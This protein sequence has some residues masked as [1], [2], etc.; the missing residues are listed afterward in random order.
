MGYELSSPN[1]PLRSCFH[2]S[3]DFER[4]FLLIDAD[5]DR[6]RPIHIECF[7]LVEGRGSDRAGLHRGLRRICHAR[8][9]AETR[10]DECKK[11]GLCKNRCDLTQAQCLTR[12][13]LLTLS[14]EHVNGASGGAGTWPI[15]GAGRC[16]VLRAG[17]W[18]IWVGAGRRPVWRRAGR[19]PVLWDAGTRSV[20]ETSRRPRGIG[21]LGGHTISRA[22][23]D[24]SRNHSDKYPSDRRQ[25]P[26]H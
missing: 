4:A 23:R 5:E 21:S 6:R 1:F 19:W 14:S 13:V 15:L 2:T 20:V 26:G 22:R 8:T 25:Q 18:S 3:S 10:D 12:P 9:A 11:A 16:P 24:E 17:R 7:H